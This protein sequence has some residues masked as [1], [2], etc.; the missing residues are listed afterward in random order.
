MAED[1]TR[2]PNPER[3][4]E[5]L[6]SVTGRAR[7]PDAAASRLMSAH[8]AALDA[9]FL[10]RLDGR[11]VALLSCDAEIGRVSLG[12]G[13]RARIRLDDPSVSQLHAELYWDSDAAMHLIV[14]TG[15]TNGTKVNGQRITGPVGLLDGSR[16][17]LGKTELYYRRIARND[18][19]R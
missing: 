13:E 12:R 8:G 15:S 5:R 7:H 10:T 3:I 14:D 9:A 16:I 17:R 19:S 1:Q 4:N 2:K 18:Q 6:S 11:R